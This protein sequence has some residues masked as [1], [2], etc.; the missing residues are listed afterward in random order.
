[1]EEQE[2]TVFRL[3]S[4]LICLQQAL[5][6]VL[7]DLNCLIKEKHSLCQ[8]ERSKVTGEALRPTLRLILFR[9]RRLRTCLS[10]GVMPC[11]QT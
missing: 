1:M 7:N 10:G 11:G 8:I 4:L 6:L 3:G 9:N 2:R 5:D